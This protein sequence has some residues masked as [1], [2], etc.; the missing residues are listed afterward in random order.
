MMKAPLYLASGLTVAVAASAP[1]PPARVPASKAAVVL[2][3]DQAQR[4]ARFAGME[5]IF[6]TRNVRAASSPRPLAINSAAEQATGRGQGQ[7]RQDFISAVNAELDRE[8][9]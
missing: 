8:R 9:R 4:E 6:L 7:A 5:T 3:W 2:T 1:Q